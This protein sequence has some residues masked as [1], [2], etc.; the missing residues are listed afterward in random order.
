[1][2]KEKTIKQIV[3]EIEEG[4]IPE[5]KEILLLQ[6]IFCDSVTHILASHSG[7]TS[8]A[9]SKRRQKWKLKN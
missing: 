6:D 5:T 2:E 7:E 4:R 3:A 9:R 1:M 8:W